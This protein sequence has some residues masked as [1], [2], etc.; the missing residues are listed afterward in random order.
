MVLEAG[1]SSSPESR[2]A[3]EALCRQYWYP[4]YAYL[5]RRGGKV[6][7]AEDLIQ[8]FFARLIERGV[9]G[10]PSPRRGRFRSFLLTALTNFAANEHEKSKA[11]KRGGAIHLVGIDTAEWKYRLEPSHHRTPEQ[12]YEQQWAVTL[13][14]RVMAAL[15][16]EYVQSRKQAFFD[17]LKGYTLGRSLGRRICGS[18]PN[19]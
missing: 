19:N 5:Q 9:I 12:L 16:D 2:Q 7:E 14:D 1:H 18:S 11:E 8:S 17:C 3:L 15:R 13:L 4:L 6:Q 10:V